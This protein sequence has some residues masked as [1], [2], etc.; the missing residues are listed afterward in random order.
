MNAKLLLKTIFL[1]IILLL[2]VM[3]GMYNRSWVEFS[4]PPF[5]RGIRQPSGIMYFAFFAV[6]LIT[7]TILTA[8]KKGG[9]SSSGSSKPK[10]SK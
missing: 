6:G 4:L 9:G 7:G 10:A 8:G 3:I 1:I 5:V 2:L